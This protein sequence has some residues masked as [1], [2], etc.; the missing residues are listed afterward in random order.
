VVVFV[1]IV[2]L[3]LWGVDSLIGW[4]VSSVIG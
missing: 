4:V 2:A 3:I 1:L